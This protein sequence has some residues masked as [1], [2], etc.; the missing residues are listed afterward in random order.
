MYL[1]FRFKYRSHVSNKGTGVKESDEW[2]F[3]MP[4]GE[5]CAT[6]DEAENYVAV[7]MGVHACTRAHN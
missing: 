7:C 1:F 5:Q 6:I 3:S 2:E 4:E